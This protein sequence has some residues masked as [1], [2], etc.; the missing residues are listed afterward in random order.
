MVDGI[1]VPKTYVEVLTPDTCDVTLFR[2]RI[3]AE[4]S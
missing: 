2:T 4:K 3:L 1:M